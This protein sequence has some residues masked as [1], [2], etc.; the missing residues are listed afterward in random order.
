MYIAEWPD[1]T[2]KY[3]I[4]KYLNLFGAQ[5]PHR[6]IIQVNDGLPPLSPHPC[7][8]SLSALRYKQ[9]PPDL[10][11]YAVGPDPNFSYVRILL[12]HTVRCS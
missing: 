5:I 9:L 7:P 10:L 4:C 11:L 2:I 6:F 8:L 1:N 3:K 12:A